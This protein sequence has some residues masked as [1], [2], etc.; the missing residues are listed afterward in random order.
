MSNFATGKQGAG[1]NL[2]VTM[3][4]R[5]ER[6]LADIETG[7]AR[8]GVIGLGY[9]G[10]PLA[11]ACAEAG[12]N[13]IGYDIDITKSI[14][15]AQ[16]ISYITDVPQANIQRHLA[17]GRFR[18]TSARKMRCIDRLCAHAPNCRPRA[19]PHLSGIHCGYDRGYS[20]AGCPHRD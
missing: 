16:G 19:R 14:Q 10:L 9:V 15:L 5:F 8:A 2:D 11:I 1:V 12:F 6:M 3:S 20:Q 7:Q 4:D 18:P 17:S 13:T